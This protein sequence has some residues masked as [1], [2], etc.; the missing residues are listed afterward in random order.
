MCS[1][2][3]HFKE[4]DKNDKQVFDFFTNLI[5]GAEEKR[6]VL[7]NIYKSSVLPTHT[8][9]FFNILV[10]AKRVDAIKDI[11]KEFEKVYNEIT[12]TELVLVG[13]VVKLESEHFTQIVKQVQK[14]T[15]VK[16]V[17]IKMEIDTSL[18]AGF[19]IQYGNGGSKLIDMSVKKQLEEIAAEVDLGDI[20]LAV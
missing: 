1:V 8:S 18:I 10:E 3:L 5:I 13:S 4:E 17:R 12:D 9:N 20:Q 7:D 16:N 2:A 15:G 14:L 19:T 11:V 6:E